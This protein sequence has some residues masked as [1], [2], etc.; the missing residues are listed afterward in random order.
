MPMDMKPGY[1]N[2]LTMMNRKKP[3]AAPKAFPLQ[4]KTKSDEVQEL[5][6][7]KQTMQNQMLVLKSTS[8]GGLSS[9]DLENSME[10]KLEELTTELSEVKSQAAREVPVKQED[11]VS[12]MAEKIKKPEYDKYEKEKPVKA[13]PGLYEKK[14]DEEKQYT[15][16]FHPYEEDEI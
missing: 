11:V 12:L 8:D 7:K 2:P 9:G 3:G 16:F 14:G 15:L 13:S 1:V 5:Q 10:K 6:T 4:Q